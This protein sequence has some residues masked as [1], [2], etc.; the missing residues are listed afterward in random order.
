M[1]FMLSGAAVALTWAM[2][3]SKNPMLGFPCLIFWTLFSGYCY[4]ESTALWDMYYFTFLAA[5]GMGI[6]S[7]F[8]AYGLRTKKEE[9]AAGEEYI[10]EGADDIK[11]IDEVPSRNVEPEPAIDHDTPSGRARDRRPKSNKRRVS[12]GR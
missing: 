6:F 3:Q 10:D 8:A 4:Q 9:I 7:P 2:F 1:L 5:I 11:F 12:Y